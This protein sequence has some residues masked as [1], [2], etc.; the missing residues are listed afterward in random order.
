M[1]LLGTAVVFSEVEAGN[2]GVRVMIAGWSVGMVRTWCG[3]WLC[4]GREVQ[5]TEGELSCGGLVRREVFLAAVNFR[6]CL[7]SDSSTS[8]K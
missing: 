3:E 7:I 5:S 1:R 8:S 4:I 6:Y 2:A